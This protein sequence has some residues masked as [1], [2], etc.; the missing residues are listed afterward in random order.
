[1]RT[2]LLKAV[3]FLTLA[4]VAAGAQ[5]RTPPDPAEMV[6]HR[7]DFLTKRLSL[8]AQQQQQATSIYTEE[9]SN[10][11][12]WHDQMR[13]AHQSLQAA[14]QKNDS[15]AIEQA[16]NT[17]GNLTAQMTMAHAKAEAAL[18]QTLT[19]DQQ[20]KLGQM[21]SHRGAGMHGHGWR[22]G[23]PPGASFK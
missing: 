13:T 20:N 11:R 19:P 9:A 1:M 16:A 17:I 7:V 12:A 3:A 15:A 21:Q 2:S 23:P 8:N 22:G 10:A 6:Q 5:R 18:F 4:V 14:V